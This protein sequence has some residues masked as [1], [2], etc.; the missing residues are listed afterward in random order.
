MNLDPQGMDKFA[1]LT[2]Q[3][4]AAIQSARGKMEGEGELVSPIP[5]DVPDPPQ[6]H[7]T[8]GKP[9]KIW[10]YRDASGETQFYVCRFD[11]HGRCKQFLPLSLWREN[12]GL[13]WRW[14]ALPDPRPLYGLDW[15]AKRPDASVVNCEGEKSADAAARVFPNSVCITSPGGSQAASKADWSPLE[16]R[17]VL[18]WPDADEPGAKYAAKVAGNLHGQASEVLMIDAMALASMAPDGG[19]REPEKGWDAAGAIAE[20][21][22]L[23]AL[24]KAAYGLAKPFEPVAP[25]APGAFDGNQEAQSFWTMS[26]LPASGGLR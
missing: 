21:E 6:T 16:A 22:N 26:L 25:G 14:K 11:L 17:R 10:T 7:R 15:L 20:W 1:P 3:E 8:L 4:R 9:S 24:R 5:L 2:P 19:N 12:G 13:T 18:V 23:G